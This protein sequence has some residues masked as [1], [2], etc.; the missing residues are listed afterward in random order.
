MVSLRRRLSYT[1][2]YYLLYAMSFLSVAALCW[3]SVQ[4]GFSY[5]ILESRDYDAY[6][7]TTNSQRQLPAFH[8]LDALYKG[9]AELAD[10]L[11]TLGPIAQRYSSIV[12]HRVH[13]DQLDLRSIYEQRYDLVLAKPELM[14]STSGNIIADYQL[15]ARYPNYGSQLVSLDGMPRLSL[16]YLANRTLGLLDDPNSVSSYQIP[17]AALRRKGIAE[18]ALNIVY[19]KTHRQLYQALFDG[20]VDVVASILAEQDINSAV[21]LPPGLELA[22]GLPGPAWYIRAELFHTELHCELATTLQRIASGSDITYLY[23][24]QLDGGCHEDT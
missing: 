16:A 20:E 18:K 22:A 5:S 9:D 23:Q 24:L 19:F 8:I 4:H 6:S 21:Q 3:L 10:A 15:I 17:K 14:Q 1:N 12:V 7:C 13:R 11:C 2:N